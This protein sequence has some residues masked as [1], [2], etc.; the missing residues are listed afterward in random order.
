M[1]RKD[2]DRLVSLILT[3]NPDVDSQVLREFFPKEA[4]ALLQ[5][6]RSI[7][8]LDPKAVNDRFSVFASDKLTARQTQFL[9]MLKQYI[10]EKGSIELDR[11]YEDP[12]SRVADDGPEGIFSQEETDKLINVINSFQ[13]MPNGETKPQ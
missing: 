10:S 8:H 6:F 9:R 4:G 11:L 2:L 13:P 1:S 5:L 7:V 3:E 12:F